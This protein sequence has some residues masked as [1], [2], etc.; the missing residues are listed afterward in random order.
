MSLSV[1][2]TLFTL[3]NIYFR[4]LTYFMSVLG[5]FQSN[6]DILGIMFLNTP[7][8]VKKI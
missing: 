8:K 3:T 7:K 5:I 2:M 6:R 4:V 1:T